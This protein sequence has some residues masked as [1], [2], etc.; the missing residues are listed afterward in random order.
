M[1]PSTTIVGGGIGGFTVAQQLRNVGYE[2]AVA[3]IDE[4]GLPYD[5]PPLSKEILTGKKTAE[6]IRFVPD[7]W[8]DEH[9]VE[10]VQA[11]V[12]RI[13]PNNRVVVLGDGTERAFENLVLATGGQARRGATPGFT[14]DSVIVLRTFE[15][16]Q[17]LSD[18]LVPGARI[19]IIGAGLIGAEVASAA[20]ERGAEVV[21]IDPAPVSLVPAVG[22]ELAERLHALHAANGV[23]FVNGSTTAVQYDN[24]KHVLE[25]DGHDS[26]E[27]DQVLLCIGLI[28][29]ES[30]ASSAELE[31]DGGVLVDHEQRTSAPGI[32]AVGDCSRRRNADGSLERRHE[33]WEAAMHDAEAAAAS[34]AGVAPPAESAPWFWSDRYGVHVEGVGSMTAEGT[35]VIRPDSEGAPVIAFRVTPEGKLAGAAAYDDSKAVRAARRI[36]DR[37]INV[38]PAKLA[39]PATSLKKLTR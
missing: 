33:H 14:D 11:R 29:D 23:Q 32:W 27:V 5:R 16:A 6:E 9:N 24:G 21:L 36:I 4:H 31:R 22:P 38:D 18:S 25:I 13:D 28:P 35:T 34:I 12:E 15:D 8:Y 17:R 26:I 10:V 1:S 7:S 3:I 2:G 37:G 20:R 30:L 39:D 19:G